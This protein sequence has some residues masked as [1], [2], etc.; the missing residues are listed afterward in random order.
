MI[1]AK[2]VAERVKAHLTDS[3]VDQFSDEMKD[4]LRMSDMFESVTP[5]DYLVPIDEMA[6]FETARSKDGGHGW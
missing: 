2:G 3:S 6:G 4:A 5:Q 1:R